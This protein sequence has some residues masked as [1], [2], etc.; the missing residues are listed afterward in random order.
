[1]NSSK[2]SLRNADQQRTTETSYNFVLGN[3][4]PT[5][6]SNNQRYQQH[7]SAGHQQINNDNYDVELLK[8]LSKDF[9]DLLNRT[10][11]SDCT[12][13]AVHRCVLVA[14]SS[15]FS[16][17]MS[18]HI[19]RLDLDKQKELATSTKNDK[20]II[21]INKTDPETMK[22]VIVFLYTAKCD[23]NERN[24]LHILDAAGRY[25][26]KSLK[27]HAAQF[28]VNHI[29]TNNVLTLIESAYKYDNLL[30]KQRCID[31]F[32]DNSKEIM[33]I[34]ELW[35]P[36]SEKY[37]MIVSELLYWIVHQDEHHQHTAQLQLHSQW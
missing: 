8:H 34:T 10:D 12:F 22:L 28:L 33:D 26:I 24:A 36:F 35:K 37:P 3:R 6:S 7:A 29:N 23:L 19:N 20:L 17:V 2:T 4:Y 16:A 11:I 21:S 5:T 31:Y 15:T 32:I 25:D 1:M 14:R 30:L 27:V 13:M 9:S 18:G